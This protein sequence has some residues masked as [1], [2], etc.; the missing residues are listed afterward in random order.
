MRH[1]LS[2]ADGN[3]NRLRSQLGEALERL[4]KV[5]GAAGEVHVSKDL[6]RLLNVTDNL[7][8]QRKD[9]YISSELFVLAAVEDKG[10]W[11][12]ML[13]KAGAAKGSIEL[14]FD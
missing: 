9:Q 4:P 11:G 14:A 8:Q 1:L 7:A 2:Q 13:R 10:P 5:V 6:N 3:V 12:E